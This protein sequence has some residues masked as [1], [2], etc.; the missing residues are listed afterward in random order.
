M[1]LVVTVVCGASAALMQLFLSG[2]S[3]AK[4]HAELRLENAVQAA[5][6]SEVADL[7]PSPR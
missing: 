5:V 2:T 3:R 6:H 4:N 7:G 1:Y